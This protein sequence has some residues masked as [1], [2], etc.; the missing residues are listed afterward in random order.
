MKPVFREPTSSFVERVLARM[1]P[2]YR[3]SFRRMMARQIRR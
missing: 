3:D 1:R 2:P